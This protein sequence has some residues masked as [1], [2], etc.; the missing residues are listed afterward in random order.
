MAEEVPY[1]QTLT[2]EGRGVAWPPTAEL[3]AVFVASWFSIDGPVRLDTLAD[4]G[5]TRPWAPVF[6]RLHVGGAE[7]LD[8]IREGRPFV[9]EVSARLQKDRVRYRLERVAL[10]DE[11]EQA[12]LGDLFAG[13]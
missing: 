3:E 11:G 9:V 6:Q 12:E 1:E 4:A 13:L 7:G 2:L 10:Q 5:P 8:A